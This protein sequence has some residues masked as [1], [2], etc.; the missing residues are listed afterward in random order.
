MKGLGADLFQPLDKSI[1]IRDSSLAETLF[2][3][4]DRYPGEDFEAGF[5]KGR[6]IAAGSY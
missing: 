1:P 2:P 6:A 5:A 3:I 4:E